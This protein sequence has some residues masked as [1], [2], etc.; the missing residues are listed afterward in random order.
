MAGSREYVGGEGKEVE[1]ERHSVYVRER[2]RER[3]RE[4]GGMEGWRDHG[5][6]IGKLELAG[7][8]DTERM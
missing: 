7:R 5:Y 3:E 2:E 8:S 6:R 4:G 1:H